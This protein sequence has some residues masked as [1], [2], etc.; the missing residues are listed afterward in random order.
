MLFR[1]G[2]SSGGSGGPDG[3]GSAN[4]GRSPATGG[5]CPAG[6]ATGQ[7]CTGEEAYNTCLSN[8]CGTQIAACLGSGYLQGSFT[9]PCSDYIN[10][11]MKCP[12]D[13][14]AT[15]CEN[16]CSTQYL[17]ANSTCYSCMLTL[18]GCVLSSGCTA[19]DCA[20]N[21]NTTTTTTTT[22]TTGTS[23]AALSACCPSLVALAGGAMT[24][25]QC[26]LGFS[27]ITDAECAQLLT[28]Y[29]AG[30]ICK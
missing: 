9:G 18:A 20:T 17:T 13:A 21:T 30:G 19:P 5:Q 6:S 1:S 7:V 3:G 22:T 16:T 25:E 15:T 11:T 8:T 27:A 23:C 2:G 24:A 10:C 14:N 4:T 26:Q 29:K 12:C 28:S